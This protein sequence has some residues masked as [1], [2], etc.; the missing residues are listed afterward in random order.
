MQKHHLV[1]LTLIILQDFLGALDKMSVNGNDPSTLTEGPTGWFGAD[2]NKRKV[3][4]S[5]KIMI[6]E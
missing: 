2:C 4:G 5:G 6:C 3:K 1:G